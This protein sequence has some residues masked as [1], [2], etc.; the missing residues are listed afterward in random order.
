MNLKVKLLNS[1]AKLPERKINSAGYDLYSPIDFVLKKGA[2]LT[3]SLNIAIEIPEGY[4]GKIED[5]SSLAVRGARTLAGV[6]D[7]N[8]RNDIS[9]V[10]KNLGE[11]PIKIE[12]GER[13]AQLILIPCG[14]FEVEEIYNLSSS[15][16]MSG[17][18]STGK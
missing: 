5:R 3:V 15:E 10:L 1:D 6:I 12:K 4:F 9:I 11:A 16:R 14:A 13:I 18:G 8:Y 2:L 17:F 7:S